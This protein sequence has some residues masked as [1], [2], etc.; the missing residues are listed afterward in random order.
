MGPRANAQYNSSSPSNSIKSVSV[1]N[2]IRAIE[3]S[4]STIPINNGIRNLKTNITAIKNIISDIKKSTPPAQP[5]QPTPRSSGFVRNRAMA[6]QKKINNT[7]S[8]GGK[9]RKNKTR[10]SRRN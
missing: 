4:I 8:V 2:R 7:K 1:K 5:A 3:E 10:K 6:I 9:S